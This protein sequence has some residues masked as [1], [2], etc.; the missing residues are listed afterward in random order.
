MHYIYLINI[1]DSKSHDDCPIAYLNNNYA[2]G[3]FSVSTLG[4]LNYF[5]LKDLHLS[6]S[7]CL[8]HEFLSIKLRVSI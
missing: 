5:I 2:R 8:Q 4:G 1:H 7:L 3:I 6:Q